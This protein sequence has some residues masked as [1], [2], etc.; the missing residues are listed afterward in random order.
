MNE[1]TNGES[2][3]PIDWFNIHKG[4]WIF[5]HLLTLK[6][7]YRVDNDALSFAA[8]KDQ[9]NIRMVVVRE[10]YFIADYANDVDMMV[11]EKYSPFMMLTKFMFKGSRLRAESYVFYTLME[12]DIEYVR[13]GAKYFKEIKK[14]DRYDIERSELKVW[15]KQAIVDDYTKSIIQEIPRYDDF[16]IE[17]DNINYSRV[18]RNNYNLYAPFEHE[19]VSIE[20]YKGKEG[21]VW[22]EKLLRHI[23]AEQYE[24]GLTYLQ[25][26]YFLPKQALPILVLTSKERQTGKSTMID[27]F[28]QLWGSNMVVINP[29]DIANNH[30][31]AYADKNIIAIEESRFESQ[32]ANEK[33]KNLATQKEILVNPKFVPQYS[34]P[35]YGKLIITSNDESKFSRVDTDEIRYW[36]RPVPTL[37]GKANHQIL[38]M[39]VSE[40]PQFLRFLHTLP[41]VDRTKSRMVF[42]AAQLNTKALETVKKESLPSLH[43][44]LLLEFEDFFNNNPKQEFIEFTA[45]HIKDTYYKNNHRIEAHY[46]NKICKNSMKLSR[47]KMK[48]F[49]PMSTGLAGEQKV[50]GTPFIFYN[51]LYELNRPEEEN[52]ANY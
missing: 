29:Q 11:G 44:D 17:P 51:P 24:L 22:T 25:V 34:I 41:K 31:A 26:L 9:I 2:I 52:N 4:Q 37:K 32:Q 7:V 36:V 30:N 16:T 45:K 49:I 21:W 19:P 47:S 43:K 35:F 14:F 33:L 6:N 20:D 12:N 38:E 28:N 18:I 40:I 23:F 3:S 1:L 46:I 8:N 10:G 13:I 39:L 42:E 15:D 27:W 5:N 50:S 48:R